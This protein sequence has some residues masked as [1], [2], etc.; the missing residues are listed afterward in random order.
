MK[1]NMNI[2]RHLFRMPFIPSYSFGIDH[3]HFKTK[4]N[5]VVLSPNYPRGKK[6]A[7]MK[8]DEEKRERE[9]RQIAGSDD[10]VWG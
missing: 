5:G 9:N 7:M 3:I 6:K 8:T 2:F 10:G 1:R 4:M